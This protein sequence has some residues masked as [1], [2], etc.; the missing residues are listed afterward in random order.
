MT[1]KYVLLGILLM[2]AYVFMKT[3]KGY[4]QGE[5]HNGKFVAAYDVDLATRYNHIPRHRFL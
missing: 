1:A 3:V 4:G 2:T 5:H